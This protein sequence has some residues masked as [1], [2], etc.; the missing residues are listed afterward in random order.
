[1]K[2]EVDVLG[3]RLPT[4]PTVS[5]DVRATMNLNLTFQSLPSLSEFRS[6]VNV[7]VV[8]LGS[9]S[10]TVLRLSADVWQR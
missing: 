9:P 6:C 5:V 10:L 7:E 8:V 3:S 1:M 4:I 2:V